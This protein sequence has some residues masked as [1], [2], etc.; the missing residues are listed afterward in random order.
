MLR[1]LV[2]YYGDCLIGIPAIEKFLLS[3]LGL[4]LHSSP[5]II[6]GYGVAADSRWVRLSSNIS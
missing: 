3:P 5:P 1:F 2:L 6:T 4:Y